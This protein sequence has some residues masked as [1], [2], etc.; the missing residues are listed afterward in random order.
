MN[1]E[2]WA[3]IPARGGSK[4][5]PLKNMVTLGNRPLIDY[6]IKAAQASGCISRIICST[7]N[8][9]I[10]DYCIKS[11]VEV[12]RRP[13]DL[14][15]DNVSTIDVLV[16]VLESVLKKEGT[17]AK[18][19]VL[20]EPTSPFVLP[21]HIDKCVSLLE[22]NSHADSAQTMTTVEPNS[23]AYNQRYIENN[24]AGFAFKEKRSLYYNKQLKPEFYI[25]GNVRVFR[26]LSFLDKK[27]IFGD[28]SIPHL[29]PR[30]YAMDLDGPEDLELAQCIL[31]CGLVELP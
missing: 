8:D 15:E 11:G 1:S 24:S 28:F 3:I 7:D 29:I 9:I 27:D 14:S 6:G 19:I 22:A 10:S 31:K 20:L 18:I 5:I 23:H 25:H 21:V 12:Q 4:S 17:L 30:K 16:Y 2:V 13:D 26:T